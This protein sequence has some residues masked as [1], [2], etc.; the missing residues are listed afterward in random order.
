MFVRNGQKL[1]SVQV[2][3]PSPAKAAPVKA[4]PK[5]EPKPEA[6]T[7]PKADEQKSPATKADAKSDK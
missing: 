4:A 7:E 3:E 1:G 2:T 5:A 6:K